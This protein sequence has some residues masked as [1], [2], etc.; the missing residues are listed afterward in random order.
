MNHERSDRF[1]NNQIL[2]ISFVYKSS[3]NQ[4]YLEDERSELGRSD[5]T[6][7]LSHLPEP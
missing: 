6:Q 4:T 1:E 3:T 2:F 7:I 5:A